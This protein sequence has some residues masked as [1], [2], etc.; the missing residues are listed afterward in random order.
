MVKM[1]KTTTKTTTKK[2]HSNKKIKADMEHLQQECVVD[3]A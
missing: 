2:N 1:S 3:L